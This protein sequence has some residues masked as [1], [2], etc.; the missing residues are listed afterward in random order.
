MNVTVIILYVYESD[1]LLPATSFTGDN[2]GTWVRAC[3]RA[4]SCARYTLQYVYSH[5]HNHG[6]R[7]HVHVAVQRQRVAEAAVNTHLHISVVAEAAVNILTYLCCT[8]QVTI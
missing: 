1:T 5:D 2:S 3:A 8:K 4:G 6:H 7:V